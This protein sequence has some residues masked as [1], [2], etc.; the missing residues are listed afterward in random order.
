VT[1]PTATTGEHL[2]HITTQ[3]PA[4]RAQLTTHGTDTWPPTMGMAHYLATLTD[5]ERDILA[6]LNRQER[7]ERTP[8]ALGERPVPIR[9]TVLDALR[10]IDAVLLEC[11]DVIAAATQRPA[12]TAVRSAGPADEIGRQLHLLAV[13]DAADPRRWHWNLEGRDGGQAAA[14]LLA[15]IDGKRGPCRDL[16]DTERQIIGRAAATA[17]ARLDRALGQARR[18]D[19]GDRPCPHCGGQLVLT[20]PL[21][22]DPWVW[23]DGVCGGVWRGAELAAL[24]DDLERR[25]AA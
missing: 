4:L 14:W 3:Y 10:E 9:L 6:E 21:E 23:C 13:R 25:A 8:D 16:T 15:R 20:Q 11:A 19:T 2:Q 12:V 22:G 18:E 24:H 17:R 7:A 5:Q 1:Q